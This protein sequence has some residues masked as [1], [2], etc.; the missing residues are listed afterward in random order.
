[1]FKLYYSRSILARV[2]TRDTFFV[3][4]LLKSFAHYSGLWKK[5]PTK[6]LFRRKGACTPSS[7]NC[8]SKSD[9]TEEGKTSAQA[10]PHEPTTSRPER[11][12]CRKEGD[13]MHTFS[14]NTLSICSIVRDNWVTTGLTKRRQSRKAFDLVCVWGGEPVCPP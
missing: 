14:N 10:R 3:K 4:H 5:A 8:S 6:G 13:G 9:T 12:R 2:A 1:M 7:P 11:M